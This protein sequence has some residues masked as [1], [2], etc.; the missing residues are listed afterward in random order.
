MDSDVIGG[1]SDQQDK[2][3]PQSG[4]D[5]VPSVQES[6]PGSRPG[7]AATPAAGL[8]ERRRSQRY[9]CSG[10]VE[11]QADG[12]DVRLTGNLTDISLHGCYVEMPTTFPVETQVTL[13]IDA[14]GVRFKTR[15]KVRVTYPFLGMGMCFSET[16]PG[17]ELQLAEILKAVVGERAVII[18]QAGH[19]ET[20]AIAGS[21]DAR[22]CVEA[23]FTFFRNN[24]TLSRDEFFAIAKRV[25][26][27]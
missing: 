9:Q 13:N 14:H 11:I 20:S 10:A 27:S 15:A 24:S 22:A 23:I 16:E 17:Q 5:R 12:G 26:H 7:G 3:R 21:A 2:T 1:L 6:G 8:R 25:R 19:P 18:A 4:K